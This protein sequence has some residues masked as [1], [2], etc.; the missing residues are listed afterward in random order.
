MPQLSRDDWRDRGNRCCRNSDTF[1][2]RRKLPHPARWRPPCV[3]DKDSARGVRQERIVEFHPSTRIGNLGKYGAYWRNAASPY[4]ALRAAFVES[5]LQNSSSV[6]TKAPGKLAEELA[7]GVR[8]RFPRPSATGMS[9][10]SYRDVLARVSE[11]ASAHPPIE[12]RPSRIVK[13]LIVLRLLDTLL[14]LLLDIVFAMLD[15]ALLGLDAEAT[16]QL[17][18]LVRFRVRRGQ[19]F[20]AVENRIGAGEIG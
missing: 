15:A 3:R 18:V 19:Q 9:L 2:R 10:K 5:G 6:T 13:E 20:L 16:E 8:K 7:A 11:S 17:H 4:C 1:C 12:L 14:Q